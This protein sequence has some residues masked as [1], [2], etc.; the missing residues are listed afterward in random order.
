MIE[1]KIYSGPVGLIASGSTIAYSG[2]PIEIQFGFP[3]ASAPGVPQEAPWTLVFEFIDEVGG[4]NERIEPHAQG[5][6]SLVLKLYNFNKQLG[7]GTERPLEIGKL[8]GKTI[9]LHFR[10]YHLTDSDK[11]LHYSIYRSRPAAPTGVTIS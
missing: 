4:T 11:T 10:V 5:E 7:S 2:N 6:R 9:W 3:V 8:H 1:I